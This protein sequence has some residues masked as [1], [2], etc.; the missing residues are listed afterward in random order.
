LEKPD[1][2]QQAVPERAN[3][4]TADRRGEPSYDFVD[5]YEVEIG[6]RNEKR[7]V[8]PTA[9]GTTASPNAPDSALTARHPVQC[10]AAM[11]AR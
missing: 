10:A 5:Q 9:A 8:F 1:A 3:V 4:W 11:V 7:Y 2:R 6:N